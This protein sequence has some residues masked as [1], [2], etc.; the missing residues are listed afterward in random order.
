MINRYIVCWLLVCACVSAYGGETTFA[1]ILARV[2]QRDPITK[3][4]LSVDQHRKF[5]LEIKG[6]QA[7]VAIWTHMKVRDPKQEMYTFLLSDVLRQEHARLQFQEEL[8]Q[9]ATKCRESEQQF[10]VSQYKKHPV[11]VGM[12]YDEARELLKDEFKPDGLPRA[13]MG[14]YL[15][16]SDAYS[17]V[18]RHGVLVDIITK[19]T[20]NNP[21]HATGVPA[22]G[23]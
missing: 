20:S 7:E 10:R 5:K 19:E 15:L 23:R 14:A 13:E 1:D 17:I 3:A 11:R 9:L 16:E 22:P 21:A 4:I 2:S 12:P 6:D 18:F 8:N